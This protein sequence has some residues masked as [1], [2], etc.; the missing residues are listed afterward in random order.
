LLVLEPEGWQT[1]E[2]YLQGAN[3]SLPEDVQLA[4]LH[5]IPGLEH[6]VMLRPG[7]AVEYDYLPPHQTSASLESKLASGLFLAGQI[8]GTSGYEEAAAQGLIAGINAARFSRDDA[9]VSVGRDQGYIGVL[10][11]DLVSQDHSEPYRI[12]TSRAEYRLLLRQDNADERLGDLGH[13][14]GLVDADRH[15]RTLQ[16][17]AATDAALASL[18]VARLPR[19]TAEDGTD[20]PTL[21]ID[22][23]RRPSAT[24]QQLR[25]LLPDRTLSELPE[26]VATQVTIQAAYEGYLQQ[27][28][29][30]VERARR[31]E[32]ESLPADLPYAEIRNLRIE[33]R[34]KLSRFRP[35]TL[36]QA[37][38]I[39]GVTPADIAVLMV[40]VRR[41]RLSA[42]V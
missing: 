14:L 5:S 41:R 37:G 3:T 34:E 1:N 36:G 21:A 35:A 7:Y 2:V 23:L 31:L 24:Y 20:L 22:L 11:D 26:D 18:R 9:S 29:R 27:Q 33:A 19:G 17:V 4:M 16:R 12:H 38:R 10:I 15:A 32:G 40:W 25:S 28:Q 42:A 6:C 39:A 13:A 8:N 30:Q